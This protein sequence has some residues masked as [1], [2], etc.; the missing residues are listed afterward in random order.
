M[1]HLPLNVSKSNGKCEKEEGSKPV[2]PPKT[3]SVMLN[4]AKMKYGI[5]AHPHHPLSTTQSEP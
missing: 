4:E 3:P 2:A 1:S 5:K